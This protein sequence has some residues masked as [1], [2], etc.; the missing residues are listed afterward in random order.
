MERDDKAIK[1]VGEE[2]GYTM[3]FDVSVPGV[4]VYANEAVEINEAVKAK[5]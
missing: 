3:I 5:L 2:G 4:I 1:E